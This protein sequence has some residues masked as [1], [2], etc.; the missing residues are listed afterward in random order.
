MKQDE[1]ASSPQRLASVVSHAIIKRADTLSDLA[2]KIVKNGENPDALTDPP[3]YPGETV[4]I[5][6]AE[7]GFEPVVEM[8]LNS[9]ANANLASNDGRTALIAASA[10][11]HIN[12]VKR[13]LEHKGDPL[14]K[15]EEGISALAIATN[16]RIKGLMSSL[17]GI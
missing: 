15:D 4:L 8:L 10:N 17:N 6:A 16:S 11:G 13:L 9:K 2:D 1:E 3:Q 7:H 12:V 14:K 5:R